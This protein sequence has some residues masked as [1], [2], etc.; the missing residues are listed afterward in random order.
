FT[1]PEVASVGLTE[2][3]AKEKG[4]KYVAS[5]T[6]WKASAKAQSLRITYPRTKF[7]I[8]PDTYEILGCHLIGPQSATM[9]HQ[10][11]SIM[12]IDNDIRHLK[13]MIYIHPALSEA[14]L[15]AAVKA[16]KSLKNYIKED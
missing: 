9:M 4:I 11:L 2:Q 16:V 1:H 5:I 13:E 14:L 8:D 7:L 15:P 12:H 10:V 6:S 3:E